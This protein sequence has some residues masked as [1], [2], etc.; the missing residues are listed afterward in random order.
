MKLIQL[1]PVAIAT[2]VF[3][4]QSN[5][6][7][8]LPTQ[9]DAEVQQGYLSGAWRS[10]SDPRWNGGLSINIEDTTPGPT[11]DGTLAFGGSSCPGWKPFTGAVETD[12]SVTLRS[13]LGIPCGNVVVSGRYTDGTFAG[14]Y[15]AEY[16]DHGTVKLK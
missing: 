11:F 2:F 10:D 15:N 14:S 5:P 13:D 8:S 12:G 9:L 1:F 16:P 6:K 4:C 3:G 7:S